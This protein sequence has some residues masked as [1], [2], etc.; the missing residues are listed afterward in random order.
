MSITF[1]PKVVM[2]A[3]AMSSERSDSVPVN[4]ESRPGRS[5][6]VTSITE[7]RLDSELRISAA[8]VQVE[9]ILPGSRKSLIPADALIAAE[10]TDAT[11]VIEKEKKPARWAWLWLGSRS[12]SAD[13]A[14]REVR[15][16]YILTIRYHADGEV[17]TAVFHREDGPGKTCVT[18]VA[19]TLNALITSRRKDS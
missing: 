16:D 12:R 1:S 14:D 17:R 2:C 4:S 7:K 18:N 3:E 5:R 6:P 10:V 9:E 11:V 13:E 19:K 15:H 8:G